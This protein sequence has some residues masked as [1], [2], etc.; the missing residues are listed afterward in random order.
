MLFEISQWKL[1]SLRA[2]VTGC[3]RSDRGN[4]NRKVREVTGATETGCERSSNGKTGMSS[5]YESHQAI[6]F[7]ASSV[8]FVS[9]VNSACFCSDSEIVSLC[10]DKTFY[11]VQFLFEVVFLFCLNINCP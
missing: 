6:S 8:T 3:D 4:S 7:S 1:N 5:N 10:C 2:T 11:C 9:L